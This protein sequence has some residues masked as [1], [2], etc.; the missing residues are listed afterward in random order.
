MKYLLIILAS[1]SFFGC[2]TTEDTYHLEKQCREV[3]LKDVKC[4][5]IYTNAFWVT[6]H[7]ECVCHM[8]K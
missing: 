5:R 3:L 8:E 7:Y 4:D 2:T 6:D 1:L